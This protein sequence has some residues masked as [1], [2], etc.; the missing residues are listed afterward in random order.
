MAEIDTTTNVNTEPEQ[1]DVTTEP[2]QTAEPSVDVNKLRAE[3]ARMKAAMDKAA[4][5]AGD[6]KKALRAKQTAEEAAAEAE[7]EQREAMEKELAELRKERNVAQTSKKVMAF[8]GDE[9]IATS[10]ATN[11]YGAED[12]EAALDAISK[13]WTAREKKL[14]IEYGKV[15]PPG[16]GASTGTGVTLEQFQG[17]TLADKSKFF[18]EHPDE[19]TRLMGHKTP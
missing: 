19:Y 15:P 12:V 11:L 2:E 8:I 7:K 10:I 5:E 1:T 14:R 9:E 13:A 16:T 3:L 6:A 18:T 4:K 17:M